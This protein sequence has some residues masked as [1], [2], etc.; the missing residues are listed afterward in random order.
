MLAAPSFESPWAFVPNPEVYLLVAFLIGAYI[1]AIR[2]L[3]PR[4][5]PH[6]Q[7]VVTRRQVVSFV[8]AM[9][10]LFA[11]STWPLHQ[12]AEQYLYSAHMLQHMML[13]YFMPPLVLLATPEWLLR[14]I[15]GTGRVY[16]VIRAITRPV[17][18][19]LLFNAAVILTHVPGMVNASGENPVLHYSLHLALVASALGMWMCVL[20]PFAEWHIGPLG[21]PIY[22]FLQSIVPTVPAGWLT[23]AEGIVYKHY[24]T[25]VRV[26]GI[27][28]TDDQQIAGAIMKLGG[29]AFI[30]PFVVYYFVRKAAPNFAAEQTYRRQALTFEQVQAEFDSAPAPDAPR[31]V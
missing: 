9:V 29:T 16:R 28:P 8:G 5:V 12:I 11:A 21:K 4:A 22:L 14:T 13:S 30:W 18:A 15:I 17:P 31:P 25:P 26:W 7:P 2:V 27:N 1:Y 10:L 20:G 23:F 6:G 3:G 19:G 24:R